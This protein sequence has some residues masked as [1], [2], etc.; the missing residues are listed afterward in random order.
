MPGVWSSSMVGA[1][2]SRSA[3]SW[4]SWMGRSVLSTL[5]VIAIPASPPDLRYSMCTG[6]DMLARID[7]IAGQRTGTLTA[8]QPALTA[9]AS[10]LVAPYRVRA[11]LSVTAA[12]EAKLELG[13][14]RGLARVSYQMVPAAFHAG[15]PRVVATT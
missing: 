4:P 14:R 5:A 13:L 1:L 10:A 2:V 8:S 3:A 15:P 6:V 11:W 12:N 7:R 9:S